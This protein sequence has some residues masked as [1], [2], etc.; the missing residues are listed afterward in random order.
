MS[1]NRSEAL[2]VVQYLEFHSIQRNWPRLLECGQVI[3]NVLKDLDEAEDFVNTF[4]ER[5]DREMKKFRRQQATYLQERRENKRALLET[6]ESLGTALQS[7]HAVEEKLQRRNA[8]LE[9]FPQ[10]VEA[11]E[12]LVEFLLKHVEP[13]RLEDRREFDAWR[14]KA[15]EQLVAFEQ[16]EE[17]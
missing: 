6:R 3:K 2:K 10:V 11:Y 17:R 1:E 9:K 13:M 8:Q 5:M 12:S 4:Q 16:M 14:L 15:T 7:L